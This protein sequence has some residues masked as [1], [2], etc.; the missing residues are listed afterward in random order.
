MRS[1]V[2][3]AIGLCSQ[4]SSDLLCVGGRSFKSGSTAGLGSGRCQKV[5]PNHRTVSYHQAIC[6]PAIAT[7]AMNASTTLRQLLL[8]SKPRAPTSTTTTTQCLTMRQFHGSPA[9]PAYKTV[10]QAKARYRS[11]VS[12]SLLG[13]VGDQ[14]ADRNRGSYSHSRG[15]QDCS[16]SLPVSVSLYTSRRRRNEWPARGSPRCRRAWGSR[17]SVVRLPA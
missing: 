11:G 2:E 12:S 15:R 14:W 5:Q 1:S 6:T 8:R 3:F 16:L 13:V 10:E 9:R 4:S 7:P 17:R